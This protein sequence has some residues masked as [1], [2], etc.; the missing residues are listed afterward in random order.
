M[1]ECDILEGGIHTLT[2]PTYFHGVKTPNLPKIYAPAPP[3]YSAPIEAS[4]VVAAVVV[5]VYL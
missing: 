4:V 1:K 5:V 2:P 3:L